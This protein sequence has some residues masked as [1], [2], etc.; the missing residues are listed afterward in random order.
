MDHT[1]MQHGSTAMQPMPGMSHGSM[2]GMQHGGTIP[3]GGLWGPQPGSLPTTD[4]LDAAAPSSVHEAHKSASDDMSGMSHDGGAA[5]P[6]GSDEKVTYTCPMHPE[7]V[8]SQPGTCAKCGM[9][10]VRKGTR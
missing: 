4:S 8:S 2:G 1:Q 9:L 5:E 7:V 6:A 3:T 10:L